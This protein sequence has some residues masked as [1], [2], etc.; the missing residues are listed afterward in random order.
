MSIE[1]NNYR[2]YH[3]PELPPFIN[4]L[5]EE[6]IT[7]RK[8][9]PKDKRKAR[10][11]MNNTTGEIAKFG[12]VTQ[13]VQQGEKFIMPVQREMRS[14]YSMLQD[15]EE[16]AAL[17]REEYEDRIASM[18]NKEDRNFERWKDD[19]RIS[20]FHEVETVGHSNVIDGQQRYEALQQKIAREEARQQ[21][22]ST[23]NK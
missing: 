6:E 11:F 18:E 20:N 3:R 10:L 4:H 7:V 2:A 21:H 23:V 15:P 17:K 12:P 9:G 19:N 13:P 14:S 5:A 22:H 8:Y 16:R 1:N